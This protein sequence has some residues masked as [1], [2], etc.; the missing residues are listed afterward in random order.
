M[1]KNVEALRIQ[2]VKDL[3]GSI[4]VFKGYL[5]DDEIPSSPQMDNQLSCRG[6]NC[7]PLSY[8]LVFKLCL[9]L[10]VVPFLFLGRILTQWMR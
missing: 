7:Y 1:M 6:L 8:G 9:Y 4:T 2:M 5:G 3:R 10:Q